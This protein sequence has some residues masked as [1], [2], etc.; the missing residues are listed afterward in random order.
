MQHLEERKVRQRLTKNKIYSLGVNSYF[1][2]PV[3][4]FDTRSGRQGPSLG[5]FTVLCAVHFTESFFYQ[6]N[7]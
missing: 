7:K 6:E 2:K 3:V 4:A 1:S 5:Q